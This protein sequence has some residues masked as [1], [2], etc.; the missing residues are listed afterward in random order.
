MDDES[1]RDVFL[2]SLVLLSLALWAGGYVYRVA[3]IWSDGSRRITLKQFGPFVWGNSSFDTGRQLFSG[4]LVFGYLTLSRRDFGDMHLR[5]LGFT[6]Q[7][8][9]AM[10]G[11]TTG[12]FKMRL[13][14]D[15]TLNGHFFGRTFTT[16]HNKMVPTT[17][18]EPQPRVWQRSV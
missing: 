17:L 2:C 9:A 1:I 14:P 3:G 13:K 8:L 16:R 10:Q 18:A 11:A 6:K 4:R 12:F 15:G 7:H 5:S